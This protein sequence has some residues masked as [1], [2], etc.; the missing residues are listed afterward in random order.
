MTSVVSSG[1]RGGGGDL[2][3]WLGVKDRKAGDRGGEDGGWTCIT[4]AG[5]L[6]PV[7]EPGTNVRGRL[8]L[9]SRLDSDVESILV[10]LLRLQSHI[11][12]SEAG[13]E[14]GMGSSELVLLLGAGEA[15]R[16]EE[17]EEVAEGMEVSA[18]VSSAI[19]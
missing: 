18:A 11:D 9:E 14:T 5:I 2:D 16:E 8:D 6:V 19:P 12:E 10:I 15:V 7:P 3:R 1:R 4:I 17:A 13:A